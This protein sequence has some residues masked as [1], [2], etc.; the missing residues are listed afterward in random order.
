MRAYTVQEKR[1]LTQLQCN[2]CGRKILIKDGIER[3][4]VFSASCTW[5][6]FSKKDGET[7]FFDLCEKC[8]DKMTAQFVI[9]PTRQEES[10]LV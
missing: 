2:M 6:Y 3:E 9:P 7:H 10:E 8:Y 4:G 1:K 5:G